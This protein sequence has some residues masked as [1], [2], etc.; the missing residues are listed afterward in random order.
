MTTYLTNIYM[1]C[2]TESLTDIG[3]IYDRCPDCFSPDTEE[4]TD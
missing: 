4:V 3:V 1:Y 2:G